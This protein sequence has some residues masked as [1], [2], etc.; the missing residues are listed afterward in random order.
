MVDIATINTASVPSGGGAAPTAVTV[1]P[2]M[3]VP[4][5]TGASATERVST[6]TTMFVGLVVVPFAITANKVSVKTG[7]T[8]T[9]GGTFDITLYAEDG[10]SQIFTVVTASLSTINVIVS[11]ALSAVSIPAGNYWIALNP[12]GTADIEFR[13]FQEAADGIWGLTEGIGVDVGSDPI[14]GGNITISAGA[15]AASFDPTSD[16]TAGGLQTLIVRFDN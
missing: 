11:T 3:L 5:T 4:T 9:T 8:V 10:Q 13:F 15:P 7:G 6:N 14:I 2:R 1:I 16:I 12:N